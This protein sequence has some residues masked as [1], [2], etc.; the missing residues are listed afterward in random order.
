MQIHC[1][2][3]KIDVHDVE[4]VDFDGPAGDAHVHVITV[5]GQT[6]A[7]SL[8]EN[9]CPYCFS[10]QLGGRWIF[11]Q[12]VDVALQPPISRKRRNQEYA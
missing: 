8:I 11:H 3:R 6:Q 5:Y 10:W 7:G 1:V 12:I 9:A 4:H 2:A